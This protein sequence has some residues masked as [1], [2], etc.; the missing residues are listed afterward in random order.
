VRADPD[1][2]RDASASGVLAVIQWFCGYF[3]DRETWRVKWW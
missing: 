1:P 2:E 3:D